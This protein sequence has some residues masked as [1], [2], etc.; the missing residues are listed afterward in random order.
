MLSSPQVQFVAGMAHAA[1][2]I[3]LGC[4]FPLWMQWALIFYGM[5]ILALFLNFYFQAYIK[6]RG[7]TRNKVTCPPPTYSFDCPPY[8]GKPPQQ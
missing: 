6:P 4:D 5:S 2:S 1:Q 8:Q 7:A 3:A